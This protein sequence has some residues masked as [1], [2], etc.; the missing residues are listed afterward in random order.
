[1]N[2]PAPDTLAVKL[3]EAAM[4]VLVRACRTEVATASHAEL[5]AACAAM[6]ARARIVVE[7]LLDDARNAPWIAEA[8]FH[9]AAL[10]LAEA[11]I[12]SLRRR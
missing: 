10:E 3:A 6:R 8:A 12:A 2:T 4:T 1:M 9:A 11:G 5:E 7:R